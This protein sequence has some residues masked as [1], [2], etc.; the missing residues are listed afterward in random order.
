M[1]P[2]EEIRIQARVDQLMKSID[3]QR[4]RFNGHKFIPHPFIEKTE[5]I[6]KHHL[7]MALMVGMDFVP[8]S[9]PEEEIEMIVSSNV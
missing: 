3:K 8:D 7:R 2:N 5:M 9:E 1:T 4:R 6:I